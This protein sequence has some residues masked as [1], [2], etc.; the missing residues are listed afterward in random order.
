MK[1]NRVLVYIIFSL[2]SLLVAYILINTFSL[3]SKQLSIDQV[4]II[5][6][7]GAA[8]DRFAQAIQIQTV[9]PEDPSDFD[10]L[11]F[12][13]FNEYLR[14][15]YPLIDS[16][17]EHNVFNNF[18]HLYLWKG[19]QPQKKP[20]VLMGHLD[21]VPVIPDNLKYWKQPPFEGKIIKD[22]LWGRGSID[23]KIGVIGIL[24]SV[25]LLLSQNFQPKRDIY[26][27]IGHDEEIGGNKGARAIADYLIEKGVEAE[28]VLD[29]GG[30]I[31][32]GMIPGMNQN[33][34]L[35]GIAEKGSVS[36]ELEV[37]LEGGHS[38]MPGKETAIDVMSTAISKLKTNPFPAGIS[39]PIEGFVEYL[40]PEMPFF[41]KMAFANA[42][43]FEPL[44][45]K[46]YEASSSGN[47]L[48]RTTTAPTIFNSG[49]KDNIIP[50]S[51][52]ATVNFRIISGSSIEEVISHVKKTIED[53]R[54]SVKESGFNTE[55]S[56]V[57]ST[58]AFGFQTLHK[59]IAEIYPETIVSPYLV[60][61]ATDAR[62]FND[63]SEN[64]YRFLPIKI[65]KSN[66]K[67]FHGLN[68]RVAVE[69]FENAVRFYV[70]LIKN[71]DQ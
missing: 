11:Q 25:E 13:R 10:S 4:E 29:E 68:E 51:A 22:T 64:I 18:S 14:K 48:I 16:L 7:N 31:T 47:A 2:L 9:S 59:S 43:L 54:V 62:H 36:I 65:T 8:I 41:N 66:I 70:Q 28:F 53:E 1:K 69:E 5:Q 55:P 34:A 50:L 38:S 42:N 26:I 23:D 6:I 52:K 63:I 32:Q 49:V 45:L 20:I 44:I 12:I 67:A 35:I 71:S 56:K 24:E 33:V 17:L 30:S 57:S 27:A 21:V 39:K 58:E 40:G 15:S 37:E 46:S 19:T 3:R 61:G 60:V